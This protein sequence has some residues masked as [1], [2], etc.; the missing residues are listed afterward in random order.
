MPFAVCHHLAHVFQVVLIII[1]RVLL[2]ILLQYLD[3]VAATSS[4]QS[5]YNISN[6]AI[7]S[8]P[9]VADSLSGSVVLDP[10]RSL[11]FFLL[12]PVL[13]LVGRH[14]DNVVEL[15]VW[16]QWIANTYV[17]EETDSIT[18]S[19]SFTILAVSK[20]VFVRGE[21][22]RDQLQRRNDVGEGRG[23]VYL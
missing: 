16:Y 20:L 4:R 23:D 17:L 9:V 14:V 21:C 19:S 11:G 8:L 2:R 10:A 12:E 6:F 1:A 13:E 22:L 3:D 7:E 5:G 15:S 18:V